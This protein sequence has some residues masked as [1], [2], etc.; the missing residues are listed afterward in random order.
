MLRLTELALF[1]APF[2]AFVV[3]RV[4]ATEGGP[5]LRVVLAAGS[6]LVVLAALLFWLSQ[7]D[8]L[9]PGTAYRPA[10]IQDGYIVSGHSAPR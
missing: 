6:V 1:I 3:W 8:A 5:S 10:Q 7:E 4:M 2:A 9:P